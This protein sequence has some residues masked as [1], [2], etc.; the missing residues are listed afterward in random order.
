MLFSSNLSIHDPKAWKHFART[1]SFSLAH[2]LCRHSYAGS[3]ETLG[4]KLW[5]SAS[6]MVDM[7]LECP[8]LVAG[9]S[10]LEIGD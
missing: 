5:P 4:A 7:L 6:V 9:R 10:V 8:A 3:G 2:T 1:Y